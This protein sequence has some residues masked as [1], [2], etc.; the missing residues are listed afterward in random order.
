MYNSV[1][2]AAQAHA[3]ASLRARLVDAAVAALEEGGPPA[4]QA[5]ALTASVGASTQAIYTHFGGMPG[6]FEALAAEGFARF[7]AYVAATPETDD[8]VA[9]FF[10]Q[11]WRYVAWARAHP[12]LYRL[13]FGLTGGALRLHSH[14]ELRLSGALATFPEGRTAAQVMVG[15]L[16][17][18]VASGRIRPTDARLAAGQFLSATHGYVLLAITDT[19]GDEDIGLA[20]MGALGVNLMVGLGDRRQA[21]EASL[22]AAAAAA[23]GT[24][25]AAPSA[26]P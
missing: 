5:R 2:P 14:L 3:A 21:A 9:D 1:M 17:R 6:L 26:N 12:Q 16:E 19:F 8:A 18:V 22:A 10:A 24:G 11:G 23:A 15:S 4:I 13:M 20:V 7:A 25:Q